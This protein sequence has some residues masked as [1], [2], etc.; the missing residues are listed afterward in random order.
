[1]KSNVI[2]KFLAV[3]F[4]CVSCASLSPSANPQIWRDAV[5]FG[6][7]SIA[8]SL[9]NKT[10]SDIAKAVATT[11]E[12]YSGSRS[13]FKQMAID[14]ALSIAQSAAPDI[15]AMSA[16]AQLNAPIK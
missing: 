14:L 4:L 12:S 8:P 5:A 11:V 13:D 1:M 10:E 9:P 2:T 7:N 16:A 6:L 15:A 3:L